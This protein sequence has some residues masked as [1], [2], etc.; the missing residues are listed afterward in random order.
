M[1]TKSM[2]MMEMTMVVM[3]TTKTMPV[4]ITCAVF[5]SLDDVDTNGQVMIRDPRF[6]N[7]SAI[8]QEGRTCQAISLQCSDIMA[9]E[10]RAA[11][12]VHALAPGCFNASQ[13]VN[14]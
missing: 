10:S 11:V 14:C 5:S 4:M 6:A 2:T 1:M 9:V 3:K 13:C 7:D 12:E 8:G